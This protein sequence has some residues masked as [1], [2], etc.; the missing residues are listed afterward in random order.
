MIVTGD[1]TQIDL[2]NGAPSGLSEAVQKL[3]DVK[4]ISIIQMTEA[5]VVRHP[6][7]ARI[8]NAYERRAL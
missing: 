8:I 7:V 1:L 5:D 6:L 2:P 3:K 4:G